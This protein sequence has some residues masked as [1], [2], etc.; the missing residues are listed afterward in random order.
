M[1]FRSWTGTTLDRSTAVVRGGSRLGP[2]VPVTHREPS[3]ICETRADT[4]G[5]RCAADRD[6][7]CCWFRCFGGVN[8]RLVL[9]LGKRK[10]DID[11]HSDSY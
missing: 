6:V 11:G 4:I 8:R 1:L 10:G 3:T 7:K 9:G 5:F 2:P